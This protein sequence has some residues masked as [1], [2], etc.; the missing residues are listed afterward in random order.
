MAHPAR[1]EVPRAVWSRP[2][3]NEG[4]P[5]RSARLAIAIAAS[6]SLAACAG[7]QPATVAATAARSTDTLHYPG[8]RHLANIRQL[9]F[10][11]NNA[12]AYFSS[13]GRMLVFQRH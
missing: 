13:D 5:I 8:E 3:R 9:T 7:R 12:E 11:G 6:A 2:S 1:T 10:E 4:S